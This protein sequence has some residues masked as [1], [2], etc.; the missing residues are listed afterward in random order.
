[1]APIIR[2]AAAATDAPLSK[3]FELNFGIVIFFHPPSI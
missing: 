3:I 1:M 2:A